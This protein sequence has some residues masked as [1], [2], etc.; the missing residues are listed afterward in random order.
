MEPPRRPAATSPSLVALP[1]PTPRRPGSGLGLPLTVV[2]ADGEAIDAVRGGHRHTLPLDPPFHL[3]DEDAYLVLPRDIGVEIVDILDD[4]DRE[5][6]AEA[7]RDG[8]VCR[9]NIERS[10][11]GEGM[12]L[13]C[14]ESQTPAELVADPSPD[15]GW[16]ATVPTGPDEEPLFDLAVL[17]HLQCTVASALFDQEGLEAVLRTAAGEADHPPAPGAAPEWGPGEESELPGFVGRTYCPERA[18][19]AAG[20]ASYGW[21][22]RL[23]DGSVGVELALFVEYDEMVALFRPVRFIPATGGG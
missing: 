16:V 21:A 22:R 6:L 13:L 18:G 15:A 2:F 23:A 9:G 11:T 19:E 20:A 7:L 8:L 10:P 14:E 1:P 12:E 3:S 5:L 4:G 17:P